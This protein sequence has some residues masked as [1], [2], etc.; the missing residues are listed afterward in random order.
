MLGGFAALNGLRDIIYWI[1]QFMENLQ[2]WTFVTTEEWKYDTVLTLYLNR[3]LKNTFIVD[4]TLVLQHPAGW[5]VDPNHA[6]VGKYLNFDHLFNWVV[7]QGKQI[8]V[9]KSDNHQPLS[10]SKK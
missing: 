4:K 1:N 3:V 8:R 5:A 9:N 2:L 7:T 10:K 6:I